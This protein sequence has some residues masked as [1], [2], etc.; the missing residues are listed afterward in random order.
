VD[1]TNTRIQEYIKCGS[2]TNATALQRSD[3]KGL[4]KHIE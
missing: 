2:G 4:E 3:G 1:A